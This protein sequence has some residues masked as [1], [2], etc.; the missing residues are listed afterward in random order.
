MPSWDVP[1][2]L[3]RL[4]NRDQ[5]EAVIVEGKLRLEHGWP[6]DWDGR[7]FIERAKDVSRRVVENS[8]IT[9]IDPNAA[10]HRA[11]WMAEHGNATGSGSPASAN[12]PRNGGAV[13]ARDDF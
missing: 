9:R 12:A 3:V 11:R 1:W 6:I 13:S 5:I 2:E 8:P 10:D 7:A 4:A